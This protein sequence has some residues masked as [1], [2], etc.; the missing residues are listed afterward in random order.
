MMSEEQHNISQSFGNSEQTTAFFRQLTGDRQGSADPRMLAGPYDSNSVQSKEVDLREK[1][2]IQQNPYFTNRMVTN[3]QT[4]LLE[5]EE[6]VSLKY[7]NKK[8]FKNLKFIFNFYA[9]Q[10]G[11]SSLGQYPTFQV[12]ETSKQ[13]ISMKEFNKILKDTGLNARFD[14]KFISKSFMKECA[15]VQTLRGQIDFASFQRLLLQNMKYVIKLQENSKVSSP[16]PTFKLNDFDDD[17]DSAA[18]RLIEEQ[19][20]LQDGP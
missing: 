13:L 6:N 9:S 1:I 15:Q 16:T 11:L 8:A 7:L 17:D 20:K 3:P 18:W 2:K 10:S 5:P 19:L 4:K 14:R 12:I